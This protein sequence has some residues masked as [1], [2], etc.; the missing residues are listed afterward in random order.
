VIIMEELIMKCVFYGM[1]GA[2]IIAAVVWLIYCFLC[3]MIALGGKDLERKMEIRR[4][5]RRINKII[6]AE[7]EAMGE[8]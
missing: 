6:Q 3:V 1:F 4:K 2:M 8:E 7:R 5:A